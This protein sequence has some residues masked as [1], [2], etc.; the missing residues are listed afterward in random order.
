M[1]NETENKVVLKGFIMT[2]KKI[3][4]KYMDW[5]PTLHCNNE[6]ATIAVVNF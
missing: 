2:K 6:D 1:T 5:F 3:Q 4:K